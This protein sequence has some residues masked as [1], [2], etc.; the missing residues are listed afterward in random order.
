[1]AFHRTVGGR[2][3]REWQLYLKR[4]DALAIALKFS[5]HLPHSQCSPYGLAVDQE[6][7]CEAFRLCYEALLSYAEPPTRFTVE[8]EMVNMYEGTV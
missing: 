6:A 7:C 8:Q 5:R 4:R 2:T 1:M 3:N